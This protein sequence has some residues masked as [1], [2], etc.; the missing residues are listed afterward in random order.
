M[1][2]QQIILFLSILLTA[3][4]GISFSQLYDSLY[5]AQADSIEKLVLPLPRDSHRV[6]QLYRLSYYRNLLSTHEGSSAADSALL[7][8]NRL[9]FQRGIY[10]AELM[11]ATSAFEGKDF[12]GAI[13]HYEKSLPHIDPLTDYSELVR[14]RSG[15]LNVLFFTG[16]YSRAMEICLAGFKLA[17]ERNDKANT[18]SYTSLLGFIY[19]NLHNEALAKKYY[20]DYLAM[21]E[22]SS[23]Q[24]M[25]ASAYCDIS[26]VYDR[27]KNFSLSL[28]YLFKALDIYRKADNKVKAGLVFYNIGHTYQLSG[29]TANA[30]R[31]IQK[32]IDYSVKSHP[33]PYDLALYYISLGG[34]KMAMGKLP[35]ALS[36]FHQALSISSR[37]GHREDIREACYQLALAFEKQKKFDSAYF[38]FTRYASLKDSLDNDET[39]RQVSEL[40]T[41]Y[42]VEKKDQEIVLLSKEKELAVAEKNAGAL[43]RNFIMGSVILITLILFL[44]FNRSRLAQAHRLQEKINLQRQEIFHTVIDTQEKERKRIDR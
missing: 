18:A 16:H 26:E 11:L 42:N 5:R 14:I 24:M 13:D 33:N 20:S 9:H 23:D 39:Q 8:A 4:P 43:L 7:L 35:E 6:T 19:T 38:Y 21:A 27:E 10:L 37:I 34:I 44:L 17:Q 12:E 40:N 32:A 41:R 2:R 29:D 25:K 15:F 31:Y 3:F 36:G 1:R 30:L 22:A 28:D